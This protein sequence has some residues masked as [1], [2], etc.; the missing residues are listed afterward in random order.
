MAAILT[1]LCRD[2]GAVQPLFAAPLPLAPEAVRLAIW[3]YTFT[4]PDEARATGAW[5][6]RELVISLDEAFEHGAAEW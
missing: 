4:S 6:N 1:K 5:W 2:P 3:R